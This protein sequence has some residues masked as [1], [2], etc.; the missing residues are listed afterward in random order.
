MVWEAYEIYYYTSEADFPD[1]P[2]NS[3]PIKIRTTGPSFGKGEIGEDG[4]VVPFN[5]QSDSKGI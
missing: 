4:G 1:N 3:E 2:I 5:I